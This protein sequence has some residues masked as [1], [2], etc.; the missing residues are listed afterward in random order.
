MRRLKNDVPESYPRAKAEFLICH[1]E[2]STLVKKFAR[3]EK[4]LEV[5][6]YNSRR[7]IKELLKLRNQFS[8]QTRFWGMWLQNPSLVKSQIKIYRFLLQEAENCS[9]SAMKLHQSLKL[10]ELVAKRG[11]SWSSKFKLR[12][13]TLRF[14]V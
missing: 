6:G 1:C 10:Q 4:W 11:F 12:T 14:G 5:I 13:L 8:A 7:S 2:N 3:K 9:I